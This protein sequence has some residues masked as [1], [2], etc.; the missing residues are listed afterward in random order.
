MSMDDLY[1]DRK[2]PYMEATTMRFYPQDFRPGDVRLK[3]IAQGLATEYRFGG[4]TDRGLYTVAQH[5]T[6][7]LRRLQFVLRLPDLR[8]PK[9]R[10]LVLYTLFHDASEAYIRDMMRP[11][12]SILP[13]YQK[14]EES[15]QGTILEGLGVSK[16]TGE[17]LALVKDID[18]QMMWTE[19]ETFGAFDPRE[20]LPEFM[21]PQGWRLH[22]YIPYD[23]DS[24]GPLNP[25]GAKH[26]FLQMAAFVDTDGKFQ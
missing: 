14:L 20:T 10:N 25:I 24:I 8:E 4:H 9:V 17:E 6:T 26:A 12:K 21:E 22:D 2:G 16:P 3:D 1:G 7:C 13:D 19:A 15:I 18:N 5:S 11:V 23:L